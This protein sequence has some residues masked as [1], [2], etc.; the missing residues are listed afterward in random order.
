MGGVGG[1]KCLGV[2]CGKYGLESMCGGERSATLEWD[3]GDSE[4][5]SVEIHALIH[6]LFIEHL[7]G[8][9][10]LARGAGPALVSQGEEA[11]SA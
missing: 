4:D 6:E 1:W 11:S 8:T 9:A 7:L 10:D 3:C 2:S 5:V